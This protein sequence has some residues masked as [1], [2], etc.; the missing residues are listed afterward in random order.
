M[1]VVFPRHVRQAKICMPGARA[2]FAARGWSWGRFVADG[3]PAVDFIR[4]G[5]P[6]AMRTVR[7]AAG[8]AEI[9]EMESGNGR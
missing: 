5:D 4:T 9:A 7:A 2:W 8:E 6:I 1:L 3:R